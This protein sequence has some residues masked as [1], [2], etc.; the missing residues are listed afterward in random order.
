MVER[1]L[2]DITMLEVPI[3]HR[4]LPILQKDLDGWLVERN[5]IYRKVQDFSKADFEMTR[6]AVA[7][8]EKINIKIRAIRREI[9]RRESE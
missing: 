6:I 9:K 4:P 1:V 2:L 7:N 5:L 8:M 3:K